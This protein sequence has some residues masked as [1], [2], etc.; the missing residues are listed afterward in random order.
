MYNM[1]G[2]QTR[3]TQ[4][5]QERVF[6]MIPGLEKVTFS[7]SGSIHRNTFLDSPKVLLPD[8]ADEGKFGPDCCWTTVWRRGL[9]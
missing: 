7:R 3:L 8:V 5:E 4:G 9:R 2:F 1:V 6:R